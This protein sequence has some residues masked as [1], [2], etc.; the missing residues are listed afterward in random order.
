M[1]RRIVLV[2]HPRR[3]DMQKLVGVVEKRF[4]AAGIECAMS[5]DVIDGYCDVPGLVSVDPEDPARGAE[6]VLVLGGDGTILR[7]AEGARRA[8][9]P[10][11]GINFGHV[12]FLAEAERDDFSETLDAIVTREYRVEE[13]MTLDIH[14][15]AGNEL[16]ARTW[17]LNE[18]TIEKMARERMIQALIEI[19]G[20]PLSTWGCDGVI[21][22]TPT[23]STAYAF[24]AGGPV[25]WPDAHSMLIVPIAAH[26]LFA[27]PLVVSPTSVVAVELAA[28]GMGKAVMFCD[29][30][31]SW[32]LPEGCR[33]VVHRSST[34]VRLAKIDTDPFT[35]RIV[36]KFELPVLGWRG[37]SGH[38]IEASEKHDASAG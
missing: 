28:H 1:T 13:R 2:P 10:L 23:G 7:G 4:A 37:R 24:S 29:G 15:Y 6:L 11:L 26:A 22:A 32:D 14:A 18:V 8:D 17:A 30:W 36:E 16:V 27:R 21:V 25:I 19:D 31:R 12:G 5:A 9:I 20:R 33:V 3:E 38:E 34:P 35:D